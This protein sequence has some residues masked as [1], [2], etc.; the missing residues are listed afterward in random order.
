MKPDSTYSQD[1]LKLTKRFG[2]VF[3][4]SSF[5]GLGMWFY[6][7]NDSNFDSSFSI[8]L[9]YMTAFHLMMGLGL[10]LQ[11]LWGYYL[12]NLF[13]YILILGFPLGTYIS[14]KTIQFMKAHKLKN[15]F[16]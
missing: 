14:Y 9:G 3:V 7:L 16:R 12:F 6:L 10:L 13:L 2:W 5:A 8:F 11:K 15:F 4:I 1:P